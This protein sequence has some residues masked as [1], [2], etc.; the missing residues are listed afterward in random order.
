VLIAA[1]PITDVDTTA[2]EMLVALDDDLNARG[3]H[4]V[5]AELKDP[6][7]DSAI[8]YGLLD[9]IERKHFFPTIDVAVEAFRHRNGHSIDS[10]DY[11]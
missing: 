1:E 8:R 5:F 6:V 7:K 9:T 2:A 10:P 4:L 11:V 3:I